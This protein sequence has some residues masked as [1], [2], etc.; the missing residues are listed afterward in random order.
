[1]PLSDYIGKPMQ[2]IMASES[3]TKTYMRRT[4]LDVDMPMVLIEDVDGK[5]TWY[6]I[7]FFDAISPL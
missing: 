2:V 6:N 7:R 4:L 3:G 1:M 5:P